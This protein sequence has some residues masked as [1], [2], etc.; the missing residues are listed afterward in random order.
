M[1]CVLAVTHAVQGG[2]KAGLK[3]K[4]GFIQESEQDGVIPFVTTCAEGKLL[5]T[6]PVKQTL[7]V[8]EDPIAEHEV[9]SSDVSSILEDPIS[10]PVV[11]STGV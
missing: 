5:C 3:L 10:E 11:S 2:I 9:A 8:L 1:E 4:C 6:I 7:S